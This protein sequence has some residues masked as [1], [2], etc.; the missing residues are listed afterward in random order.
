V[1]QDLPGQLLVD[2]RQRLRLRQTGR[3]EEDGPPFVGA[4]D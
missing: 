4:L 3:L 1:D 2:Q